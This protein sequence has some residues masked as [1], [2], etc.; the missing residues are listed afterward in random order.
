MSHPSRPLSRADAEALDASDPLAPFRDE[1]ILP[2]N[3]IYLDGNSLG[4]LPKGTPAR[5]EAAIR[6]EWGML[7]VRGWNQAGWYEMPRRVGDKIARL[8]GAA[9]GEVVVAD[10]TSVNVF[11]TLVAALR[12]RPERRVIVSEI[13]NFPTDLYM[14]QGVIDLLGGGYD[15]RLVQ[16]ADL[17]TAITTETA[18]VL[19]THVNYRTGA[20]H[21]MAAL[22]AH[23]HAQGALI[24]WDLAHSAG[25][26]PVDL[27]AA[28]ADFAVGCGYKYLNGG[29]GAPAFLV[30]PERH[31]AGF[32]QPLSG[33][34]GHAHPFAFDPYYAP[35]EGAARALV[36]TQAVLSMT[37]LECGVDLMLRADRTLL[38]QKSVQMTD[39]FIDQVRAGCPELDLASPEDSAR[40]GSQVCFR[41][42]EQAAGY[43]IIQALIAQGVV[44]D[45]RAPDILRFGFAPLYLRYSEVWEAAETLVSIVTTQAWDSPTFKQQAAVT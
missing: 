34:M 18:V 14:A 28:G 24:I 42:S 33:W 40:R 36:G 41:H 8:I 3:V 37:A 45:F 9:S 43:A 31:Q 11:K 4:A 44:G 1:F 21:D 12:L 22:T 32:R 16:A 25:A 6:E 5:L 10:S 19:L 35:A 2:P 38:R 29:P 20:M 39:L 27:N 7:L 30:V 17:P 13:D 15:L 23:A 26:V